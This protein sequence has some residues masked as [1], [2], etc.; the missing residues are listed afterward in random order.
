M[1]LEQHIYEIDKITWGDT[2]RVNKNTLEI[3]KAELIELLEKDERLKEVDIELASPGEKCRILQVADVIEPR[4][5]MDD[6]GGYFPGALGRT[7]TVGEGKTAV[8]R[9][10][11]VVIN[12]WMSADV[13]TEAEDA[14][15][16]VIDMYGKGAEVGLYGKTCNV[17]VLAKPAEEV[18]PDEYRVAIKKAGLKAASYLGGAEK[19]N[20]PQDVEVYELPPLPEVNKNMEDLPKIGYIFMVYCT[21]YPAIPGEPILYGDNIR[22][23]LP[24]IIHPNEILDG[25]V[26]N[27]YEGIGTETYVIQ[28][29]PVIK[30]IYEK[31][32]KELCFTGVI[33]TV[34]RYTEPDRER[35][36]AMAASQARNVLGADGVVLT[37]ASSGAPD[38]DMAQTAQR[39]EELGVKTVLIMF[40]RSNRGELGTVFNLPGTTAIIA[41]ANQFVEVEL[42]EMDRII[43]QNVKNPAGKTPYEGFSKIFRYIR[44]ALDQ[45]GISRWIPVQY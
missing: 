19:L 27:P 24:S 10:S 22:R 26:V 17:V 5:K 7:V 2:T 28:N 6:A 41:T 16:Y 37:K 32:G 4:C 9:G 1:R 21:S 11:A 20:D 36:A 44:G 12:D 43:G 3:H 34:S 45:E 25:A 29:H 30:S 13:V 40:D 18:S 33:L 8:L 39:C 31:H 42:S 23:F 38:I 14:M 35:A 15:G